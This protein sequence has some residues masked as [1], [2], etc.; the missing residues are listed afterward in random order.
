[1]AKKLFK[2]AEYLI[3]EVTGEDVFTP[4]TSPRSSADRRDHRAV[5]PGRGRPGQDAIENQDFGLVVQ[6]M[7][8][9]GELG[10]LMIDAPAEYGG[11]DLD[12]AHQHAG[13]REDGRRPAL[14]GLLRGPHRHRHASARLLRDPGAEGE[15]PGQDHHRR[16]ERGL[17]P[18]R[19]GR[20]QR[21]H[22]RHTTATL[23]EDGKYY[24][25]DGT[26]QFITN[27]G[28]AKLF[29]V[30]AKIDRK[31]FTAFL[32]ERDYPGV[33]VGRRRRS[34]ASRAPPPRRSSSRTPRCRW[35]TC[36]ARSARGTRSPSTCSTSGASSWA[37]P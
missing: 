20:R 35:R 5:R 36:S 2:G 17:L 9:A 1:M 7:Q 19:A 10:L 3:T 4:R 22:G 25:L 33:T 31:H 27:G 12:K 14:L 23:S 37:P 16:V 34:W 6:L 15:V 24:L 8:K 11:L 18:D 21:R 26:K 13:G 29:T 30:F 32:V 28:F